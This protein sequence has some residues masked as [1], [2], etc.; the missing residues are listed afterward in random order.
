MTNL[1]KVAVGNRLK[2]LDVFTRRKLFYFLFCFIFSRAVILLTLGVTEEDESG[3][4]T[5][6]SF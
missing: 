2:V 3:D 1:G 4:A 5:K 6:S